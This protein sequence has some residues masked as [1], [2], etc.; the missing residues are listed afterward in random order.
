MKSFPYSTRQLF[1]QILPLLV[2]GLLIV[3]PADADQNQLVVSPKIVKNGEIN[4]PNVIPDRNAKRLWNLQDA[5]ILSV[6]TE[7]S[8][9]TGKN[10]IVDPRVSGKISLVSSKPI[11]QS[12][13]YQVFLSV[14]GLLGY[15]AIPSGNVIKIVP[16]MESGEQATAVATNQLPGRGDEVVVRVIPLQ[17]VSASQLIPVLR[18]MLPQWS[19]IS[20]YTPGNVIILLGRASNLDRIHTIIEDVDRASTSGIQMIPL[21]H[22]SASQVAIVLNNLQAAGRASGESSMVSIAVDERSNSIL[23]GGPKAARLRMHV[24]ISIGWT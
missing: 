8:Q 11:K 2:S 16:N 21:R 14:L 13:V 22:A 10:F 5:D 4:P 19:N 1:R 24:L 18:P 7:V 9:E 6:I 20:A 12:E 17:N 3:L 23:L 15:S